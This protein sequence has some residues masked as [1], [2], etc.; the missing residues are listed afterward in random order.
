MKIYKGGII[1]Y[2]PVMSDERDGARERPSK[3]AKQRIS[4]L[5]E[6][7]LHECG[8]LA[9]DLCHN[10]GSREIL[11]KAA[12]KMATNEQSMENTLQVVVV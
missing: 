2:G 12:K 6:Q 10:S 9:R 11:L 8:R 5:A 1:I 4:S 7:K 3:V